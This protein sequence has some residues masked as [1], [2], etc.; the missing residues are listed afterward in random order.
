M[1]E[2]KFRAWSVDTKEMM[3]WEEFMAP[4]WF[5]DDT[6]IPMQYT[7]LKDKNGTDVYASDIVKGPNGKH[8]VIE[9][10]G[11]SWCMTN[12]IMPNGPMK[13]A[14]EETYT[15]DNWLELPPRNKW[16]EIVGNLY[17]NPELIKQ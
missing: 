2:I 4:E 6:I 5:D 3:R 15:I 10:V 13:F 7:G 9:W 17:D 12:R 8:W 11:H 14:G 1:R 16:L